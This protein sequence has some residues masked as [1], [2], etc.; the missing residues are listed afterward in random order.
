MHM[1]LS[2]Q[3]KFKHSVHFSRNKPWF[4]YFLV[5]GEVFRFGDLCEEE[6][7]VAHVLMLKRV[8]QGLS[9]AENFKKLE[10]DLGDQKTLQKWPAWF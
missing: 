5:I 8:H 2:T 6:M 3:E 7:K 9:A 4:I 1:W 10:A